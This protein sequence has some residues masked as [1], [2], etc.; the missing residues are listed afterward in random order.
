MARLLR[1]WITG[2]ALTAFIA[3]SAFSVQAKSYDDIIDAGVITIAVYNNFP[4]YSY[5]E[6]D[7][8]TGIDIDVGNAI[9]KGLGVKAEFMWI[10]ADENLED[11]LRQAVWKGHIITRQ[12]ADLM[13]R[14]PYDRKFSYGIDGYGLPRNEMVAMFGPYHRE[15]WALLKN[16]EKT[17]GIDTLAIFQ[18]EKIAVEIDSLPDT[19]LGSTIGGRLRKNMVHTTTT[20]DGVDLFKKGEVA[21]VAGMQSQLEWAQP[22]SEQ[23]TINATGLAAMSIKAWDIGMAVKTDYRQLAYAI[24]GITEPMIKDGRMQSIFEKYGVTYTIPGLY[25]E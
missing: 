22:A 1:C 3:A 17:N 2:L 16:T 25:A 21:A 11:D 8:P 15:K 23:Y 14:V 4:P 10:N 6:N 18:Y 20:F 9:A 12:K 5:L 24:E 19:F 13:L 7:K